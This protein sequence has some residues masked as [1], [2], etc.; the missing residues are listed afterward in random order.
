M[1]CTMKYSTYVVNDLLIMYTH[2]MYVHMYI[3]RSLLILILTVIAGWLPTDVFLQMNC[4]TE[5]MHVLHTV[6]M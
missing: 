5:Y 1:A 6:Y 4:D 3:H 2:Y